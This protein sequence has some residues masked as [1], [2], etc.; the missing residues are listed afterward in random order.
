M[1]LLIITI[2][3]VFILGASIGSFLSVIMQ[4]VRKKMSGMF[5][6]R[7]QCLFC[8][9]KLKAKD[10]VPIFSFLCLKGRCAYCHKKLSPFYLIVEI[11][12]GIL[13]VVL[14][15]RF[16]FVTADMSYSLIDWQ[17]IGLFS[18]LLAEGS[19]LMGIFFY[20]LQYMEIPDI[21]LFPLIALSLLSNIGLMPGGILNLL[22]AIVIALV[23]F[24]GQHFASKGKWLGQ[25]DVYLSVAMA[26]ILGWQLLIV[27]IALTYLIGA[28][29]SLI[30]LTTQKVN[31]QS[32]I[33]F[34]P[35]MVLGTFCALF[36]GEN[37]LRWY[38]QLI[39]F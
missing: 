38:L 26:G 21:L 15:L 20:D 6:G 9:K 39:S 34:A 35:F 37:I 14:F 17:N 36:F 22:I 10:L 11:I 18:L 32:K 8:R 25:G 19:L 5:W 29:I 30:L 7:S 27:A 1:P 33:A 24:G 2:V 4:R 13:S 28:A 31:K 3:F 23:F 16:P 12:M